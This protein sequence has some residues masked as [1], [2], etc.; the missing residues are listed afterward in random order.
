M[1]LNHAQLLTLKT[2]LLNNVET[3]IQPALS[4]LN[5]AFVADYYNTDSTF[6]V[7]KTNTNVEDVTEVILWDRMVPVDTPDGTQIYANR[8]AQ[9]ALKLDVLN[10][11]LSG[12]NIPSN[13]FNIRSAI[14]GA[15]QQLPTDTGTGVWT[16]AGASQ[17]LDVM[18]RFANVGESLYTTGTGSEGAPGALVVEGNLTA[19]LVWKALNTI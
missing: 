10:T 16:S 7:W 5:H 13:R 19:R 9:A 1:Q 15:L 18:K 14:Q 3:G 12:R 17:A 6:Y 8:A 11:L 2:H 4:A